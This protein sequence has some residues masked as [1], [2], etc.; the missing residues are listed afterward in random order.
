MRAMADGE[1]LVFN[2]GVSS[3][4]LNEGQLKN[5]IGPRLVSMVRS[6]EG[7]LGIY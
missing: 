7:M 5:D 3:Y 4:L 1:T 6:I 2:C